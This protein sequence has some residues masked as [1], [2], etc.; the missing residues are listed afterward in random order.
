MQNSYIKQKP[1]NLSMRYPRRGSFVAACSAVLSLAF[2]GASGAT[3]MSGSLGDVHWTARNLIV[4]Q[5]STDTSAGGGDP[6][7]FAAMPQYS[8]VA[9]LIMSYQ[10]GSFICSGSLLPDRVSLLSA[11]HCFTPSDTSGALLST[12]AFFYGGTVPDTV[13]PFNPASTAVPVANVFLHPQY[14]GEVIDQHDIAV[15]RL[16]DPAPSFATAYGLASVTDL[17]GLDFN[18]AGYGG[19]SNAGGS[20]GVNRQTGILRQGDN[21][22]D[23][24][25]GDEDFNG[26][27][28][29]SQGLGLDL[30]ITGLVF[31]A[32]FDNGQSAQD[33]TCLVGAAFSLS[34][35]K[36]CDLGRGASE[37][38]T[39]GGD[40]G[41]PQF[42]NDFNILSVTSFGLSFGTSFGDIDSE[43]NSSWGEFSGFA[44][45]YPNLSFI[46]ANLN[47]PATPV[48]GPL[49]IGGVVVMLQLRR[50]L[51]RR[52]QQNITPSTHDDPCSPRQR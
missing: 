11:A 30:S 2:G 33:S 38:N 18:T 9:S 40:S 20:V 45:I 26:G 31:L 37:A 35:S 24:R 52:L 32:D 23:F 21:R 25:F 27:W 41:G 36:Y 42:D 28:A 50:R 8:G 1:P 7:Y 14:T 10:N 29:D 49:P 15:L 6:R 17:T 51:R 39:A 12:T 16:A 3:T 22:Y 43:L 5:T 47:M 48:P 4:G 46:E 34:G 13:V 19:R 44:P